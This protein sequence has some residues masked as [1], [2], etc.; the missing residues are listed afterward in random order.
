MCFRGA[1][2]ELQ[3]CGEEEEASTAGGSTRLAAFKAG[4]KGRA[5]QLGA[6]AEPFGRPLKSVII[7]YI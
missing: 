5:Y 1:Q 3:Q 7:L 4:F 6:K 2:D